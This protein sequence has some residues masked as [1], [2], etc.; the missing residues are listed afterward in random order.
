MYH[1]NLLLRRFPSIVQVIVFY[2]ACFYKENS[3]RWAC[4][5]NDGVMD[6]EFKAIKPE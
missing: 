5:M 3:D 1:S 2:V 4:V 6:M